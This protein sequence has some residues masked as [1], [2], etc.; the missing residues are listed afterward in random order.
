MAV[1]IVTDSTCDLPEEQRRELGVVTVPLRLSF[2]DQEYR[3]RVDLDDQE[4]MRRLERARQLPRTSQPPPGEFEQAYRGLLREPDDEVI[5]IHIAAKLSGT[6]SSATI[7]AQAVDPERIQVLD[8]RTVSLGTGF[9]V[10]EAA[11]LAAQGHSAA[12]IARELQPLSERAGI[13]CLLDTLRYLELGGRIGKVGALLGSALSIKPLISLGQDGALVVLG[14]VRSRSAGIRRLQE[15]L[16][17]HGQLA[18]CGVL[19]VGD[20]GDAE[21]LLEASRRT[22]PEVEFMLQHASPVLSSHC[23]PGTL[24]YCYLESPPR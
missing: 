19:Y 23:G 18:R 16:R 22:L 24:A 4:F 7:A 17:E 3:D 21:R 12:E 9:Q 6:V 1:R 13:I 8:S 2:G 14:R 20:R 5:S 10:L 15:L 11:S